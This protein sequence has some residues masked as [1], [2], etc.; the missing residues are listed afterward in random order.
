VKSSKARSWL[1]YRESH[2]GSCKAKE[3]DDEWQP[4]STCEYLWQIEKKIL[5]EEIGKFCNK[6]ESLL[7]FACGTGRVLSF[8]EN[9]VK[10]SVGVDVSKDMLSVAQKR[11]TKSQLIQGDITMQNGLIKGQF[12]LITAFRFF[13]NAE[14]SLRIS[15][16]KALYGLLKSN[17]ILIANFHFNPNSVTGVVQRTLD[18]FR[19]R[20]RPMISVNKAMSLFVDNGYQILSVRGYGYLLQRRIKPPL[21]FMQIKVESFLAKK[22]LPPQLGFYFLIVAKK[23]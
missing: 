7:D 19:K 9:S 18:L 8:L 16:L 4:G 12:E 14:E 21:G 20:D 22:K 23:N 6:P 5:E 13:L 1:N 3:Y 15:S 10:S 17:G 11:C 2:L